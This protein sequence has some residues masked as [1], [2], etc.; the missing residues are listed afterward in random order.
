MAQKTQ[1]KCY[2]GFLQGFHRVLEGFGCR[3]R[4]QENL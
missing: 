3:F 2:I 1:F 4:T